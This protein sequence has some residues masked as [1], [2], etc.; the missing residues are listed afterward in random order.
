MSRYI[1]CNLRGFLI[2]RFGNYTV[3]VASTLW[4]LEFTLNTMAYALYSTFWFLEFT[5]NTIAYML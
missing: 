5:S 3:V 1:C 4:F 2:C